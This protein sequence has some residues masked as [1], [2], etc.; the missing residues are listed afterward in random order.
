MHNILM[1]APTPFFSDRGCHVRILEEIKVL[2]K[3]GEDVSLCTYHNGRDVPGVDICRIPNIPWYKKETAG[4]SLHKLY[5]DALLFVKLFGVSYKKKPDI[6]HMYLHEGAFIGWMYKRIKR[7]IPM[8]FDLQGGLTDELTAHHFLGNNKQ[9]LGLFRLLEG[10]LDRSADVLIVC[11]NA[12]KDIVVNEFGVSPCRIYVVPDG[13]DIDF[14]RPIANKMELRK[15]YNL[16]QDKR[17]VAY[18]GLLSRYQGIGLLLEAI[19]RIKRMRNDVHFLIMGYPNVDLYKR[20]ADELGIQDI[21]TF[22]GRMPYSKAPEAIGCADIAVSLKLSKTEANGKLL[23]YMAAGLP[24]AAFDTPVN[25]EILGAYGMYADYNN[26][27]SFVEHLQF[28]LDNPGKADSFGRAL[29]RQAEDNF[30]W[31]IIG[32]RILEAYEKAI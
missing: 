17:I 25:K 7:R 23:D 29:R 27:D 14:F 30:S 13:V 18:L 26:I 6:L 1:A 15:R 28:L 19:R 8:V 2:K 5:L 20:K 11:S 24:V 22:T 16:P 3:L 4:P 31:N 21:V 9:V 32:K 12:L 10:Y